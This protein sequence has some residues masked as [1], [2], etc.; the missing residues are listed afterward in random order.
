MDPVTQII[1]T[2]NRQNE[3]QFDHNNLN[4]YEIEDFDNLEGEQYQHHLMQDGNAIPLERMSIQDEN[5]HN[6]LF[7]TSLRTENNNQV[8]RPPF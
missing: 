7:S 3:L 2:V 8:S 6:S 5:I 4:E 1:N